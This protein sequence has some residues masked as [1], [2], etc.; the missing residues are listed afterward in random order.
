M[1]SMCAP[2]QAW[3]A[4]LARPWYLAWDS[5][6]LAAQRHTAERPGRAQHRALESSAPLVAL[7]LAGGRQQ[8]QR[9]EHLWQRRGLCPEE[10][11]DQ[12]SRQRYRSGRLS[13]TCCRCGSSIP[14]DTMC[15][16]DE[17][18]SNWVPCRLPR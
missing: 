6:L 2:S 3:V 16:V 7:V 15:L 4:L 11:S 1:R 9:S 12:A 5:G 8:W 14:L 10:T 17:S 13:H 18:F